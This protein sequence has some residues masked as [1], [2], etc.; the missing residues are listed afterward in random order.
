MT[1]LS[2]R[3]RENNRRILRGFS[4]EDR[5]GRYT[6]QILEGETIKPELNLSDWLG[7]ETISSVTLST[8]GGTVTQTNASGTITFTVSAVS[9]ICDTAATITT[10]GGRVRI[11]KLRFAEPNCTGR[12]DY[13]SYIST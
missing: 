11:E 12:D 4:F 13:G 2:I 1:D 9:T 3:I 10:S 8:T 5:T 7:T 6:C